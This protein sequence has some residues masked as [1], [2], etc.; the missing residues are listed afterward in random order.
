LSEFGVPFEGSNTGPD[1]S[2]IA[3]ILPY[4]IQMQLGVIYA[5][6]EEDYDVAL[7]HLDESTQELLTLHG[8]TDRIEEDDFSVLGL[9]QFGEEVLFTCKKNTMSFIL[10]SKSRQRKELRDEAR[11]RAEE[12]ELRGQMLEEEMTE[13]FDELGP[14]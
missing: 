10:E 1:P 13:A 8:I 12:V 11:R 7:N 3:E 2:E 4:H 14:E 5:N 9:T 6:K